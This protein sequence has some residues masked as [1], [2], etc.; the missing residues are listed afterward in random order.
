MACGHLAEDARRSWSRP[1]ELMILMHHK[2]LPYRGEAENLVEPFRRA[3]LCDLTR[4]R[5]LLGVERAFAD[6]L[7]QRFPDAGFR[8]RMVQLVLRWA[9]VH[10]SS[11]LPMVRV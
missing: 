3:D 5:P 1:V 6:A 4:G 10:P 7:E 11:P 2:L 8:R 9:R